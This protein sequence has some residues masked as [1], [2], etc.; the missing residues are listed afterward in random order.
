MRLPAGAGVV[1]REGEKTSGVKCGLHTFGWRRAVCVRMG[2][3]GEC[4][5]LWR[6]WGLASGGVMGGLG[7]QVAGVLAEG[8]RFA[9]AGS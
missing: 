3:F 5:I 6:W 1:L 8:L 2:P 9:Q 7:L 4:F